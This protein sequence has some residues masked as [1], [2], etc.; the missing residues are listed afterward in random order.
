[1]PLLYDFLES[2]EENWEAKLQALLAAV[3]REPLKDSA[4]DGAVI[5]KALGQVATQ[6]ARST[7]LPLEVIDAFAM[8]AVRYA[9]VRQAFLPAPAG[10]LHGPRQADMLARCT[11]WSSGSRGTSCQAPGALARRVRSTSCSRTSTRSS[12]A[13]VARVPGCCGEGGGAVLPG[14]HAPPSRSTS[15]RPRRSAASSARSVRVLME[16]EVQPSG[17]TPSSNPNP[18]P[19]PLPILHPHP[20]PNPNQV[21]PSGDFLVATVGLPP[22]GARRLMRARGADLLHPP[23]D[24]AEAGGVAAR[25]IKPEPAPVDPIVEREANPNQPS[26]HPHPNPNPNPCSSRA[27]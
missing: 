5:R 8:T 3:Q 25:R 6:S 2:D 9:A 23:L 20:N 15:R 4:V 13:R 12:A 18:V 26:P 21:Q 17:D 7:E 16:G 24:G 22:R 1:M 11:C 14:G 27:N 19:I 10:S